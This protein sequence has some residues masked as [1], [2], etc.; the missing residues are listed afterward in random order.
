MAS[1]ETP[2]IE[3]GTM[4]GV[5]GS[6]ASRGIEEA[7]G[8]AQTLGERPAKTGLWSESALRV[9]KER[10]LRRD[11]TGVKETPEEMCWR[12]AAAIAKAEER[13]GKDS[14]EARKVAESFYDVM[15]EGKFIPN[16]PTMMNAGKDNGLQFSACFV[17]PVEDSM[18]GIFEAVKRA[19]II[20]KSGGG[21]GFA[22][23]RLRPKD[24]LVKSTGGKASGPVSFLRVFNGA[25]EAVKQGGPRRGANMGILKVD[26]PDILEFIHCKLDGG[27]AN[28]NISVTATDKVMEALE[29]DGEYDLVDP[30]TLQATKRLRA[31][32]IF[33]RSEE[34]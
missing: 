17:L 7:V 32:E 28:F 12:V 30:H 13:W 11:A 2:K 21:T 18:E 31:R 26:H 15:V 24:T 33:D 27:I 23:S 20:H 8:V 1:A 29:K 34:R 6:S 3:E 22:F 14:A 4:A 10:Y 16:S 19:A 5:S 9:L 25:T